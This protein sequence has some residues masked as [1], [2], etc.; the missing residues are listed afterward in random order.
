MGLDVPARLKKGTKRRVAGEVAEMP[1]VRYI[2][3]PTC[4]EE[5]QKAPQHINNT[6]DTLLRT[7]E[8]KRRHQICNVSGHAGKDLCLR[9]LRGM[10]GH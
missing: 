6:T 4:F 10:H 8:K 1:F 7:H 3:F 2:R 5:Q 9:L